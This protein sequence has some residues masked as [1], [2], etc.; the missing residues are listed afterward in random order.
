M[1]AVILAGGKGR[2]LLPYTA[3]FPKPLVPIGDRPILAVV[4]EQLRQAGFDRLTLAVGH[5]AG[6][7]QAYFGDGSRFGVRIDYS[8]ET[9]PLGTAGPLS[10]LRDLDDD[11]LVM[12]GDVLTDL[13]FGA[14]V[15]AH[16]AADTIGSIAVYR[17]AVDLTLGVL[18][19]DSRDHIVH[20]EEKP[21]VHY[22]VS[23]GIY[24]FRP[25]VLDHLE[26]GVHCDLP[27]LIRRLIARGVQVRGHRFAGSWLDIGRPE[28]YEI[29]LEMFGPAA[30]GRTEAQTSGRHDWS[31]ASE[32]IS[33]REQ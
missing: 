27:D 10:L 33:F 29:A 9:T 20:Y 14:F 6:L 32:A 17:K 25:D 12:N 11:F 30:A 3:V 26:A 16:R 2:R 28:D 19:V 24:C 22:L 8:M 4:V 21:E 1:R 7:I 15:A 13:D 18:T 5:L 31:N 23:T